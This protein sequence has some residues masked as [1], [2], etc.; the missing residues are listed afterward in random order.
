MFL[1]IKR[2]IEEMKADESNLSPTR[3]NALAHLADTLVEKKTG[4]DL[5]L[6][7]ICT[8]NSRRS[9]FAQVWA[10]VL[11]DHYQLPIKAFSG[12]TE[13]TAVHE[14]TLKC[15]DDLGFEIKAG[16][17]RQN[18][19]VRIKYGEHQQIS[20]FSKVFDHSEN[21]QTDFIALMLCDHAAENCPFIPHASARLNFTFPDPKQFDGTAQETEKYK[22]ICL[23]IAIQ[24]HHIFQASVN[25][26]SNIKLY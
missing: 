24:L 12:G 6:M 1:P 18:E 4:D 19:K 21:P 9:I 23:D 7:F 10:S 8:H 17:D 16:N 5:Q 15:L 25:G 26:S 20:C 3:K 11:A 14:N 13:A 2:L 22:E